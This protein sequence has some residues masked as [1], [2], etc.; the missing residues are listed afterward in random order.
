M[1]IADDVVALSSLSGLVFRVLNA[2]WK[3]GFITQSKLR[4]KA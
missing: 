2:I 3:E 1:F 4:I